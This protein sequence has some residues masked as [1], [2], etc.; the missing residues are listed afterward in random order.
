MGFLNS[1]KHTEEKVYDATVI[2]E[3]R[4]ETMKQQMEKIGILLGR[5]REY[6]NN[7]TKFFDKIEGYSKEEL[8]ELFGGFQ[9]EDLNIGF[10]TG[11]RRLLQKDEE[12][13]DL[14]SDILRA[15][16]LGDFAAY[17]TENSQYLISVEQFVKNVDVSKLDGWA[18]LEYSLLIGDYQDQFN[19]SSFESELSHIKTYQML[20][21]HVLGKVGKCITTQLYLP[22]AE[23][24]IKYRN[25]I[26]ESANFVLDAAS[27]LIQDVCDGACIRINRSTLG[28]KAID[29]PR[30]DKKDV[31]SIC[32]DE[33]ASV[34]EYMIKKVETVREKAEEFQDSE[35]CVIDFISN[36]KSNLEKMV[37]IS[38]VAD[39]YNETMTLFANVDSL[40][41]DNQT[42]VE[43]EN[44]TI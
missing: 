4:E 25:V 23:L 16:P 29:I 8:E 11:G 10:S 28:I 41:K 31:L 7:L 32:G 37:N 36:K 44:M 13:F 21:N 39:E 2:Q 12:L 34:K 14:V 40:E 3:F 5:I 33:H 38:K 30:V 26:A 19:M 9:D 17:I 43:I 35:L 15:R 42:K 27:G 6:G 18:H 24:E 22:A 20:V 1:K